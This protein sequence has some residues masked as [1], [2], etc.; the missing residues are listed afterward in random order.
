MFFCHFGLLH[1]TETEQEIHSQE[2]LWPGNPPGPGALPERKPGIEQDV[3]G[4]HSTIFLTPWDSWLKNLQSVH[5]GGGK[6]PEEVIAFFFAE[7]LSG[8]LR[9]RHHLL[10]T[11]FLSA[12]SH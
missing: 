8:L 11:S 12:Y 5:E 6:Y 9:F 2:S 4:S 1:P 10:C 7:L 3:H